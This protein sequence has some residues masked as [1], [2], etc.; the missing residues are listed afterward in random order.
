VTNKN[1][2]TTNISIVTKIIFITNFLSQKVIFLVV[3]FTLGSTFVKKA[4]TSVSYILLREIRKKSYPYYKTIK[5]FLFF[6]Q[7]RF[8]HAT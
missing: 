3:T 1:I 6:T 2:V 7:Q 8:S 4:T 5:L